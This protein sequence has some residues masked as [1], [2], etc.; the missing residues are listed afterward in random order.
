MN[1][2]PALQVLFSPSHALDKQQL[3][4]IFNCKN[5]I[6]NHPT[7]PKA[8]SY[9]PGD[10]SIGLEETKVNDHLSRELR[11]YLLDELY[12]HLWLV[13]RR[14]GRSIDALH[15]QRLKGRS[16]VPTED[17]NL[18]LIWHHNQIY[19]KPIPVC[20]FNYDFWEIYLSPTKNN[21]H[22][23]SSTFDCSIAM[24]FLR[25]YAFLISHPLDF[26]L[27]KESH[28]VP[29]DIDWIAWSKFIQRFR[30]L[31]DEQV[32]NRFHYGQLRL[33]RLNWVV[34]I[35][36]PQHANTLWFYHIPHWSITTYLSQ[37]TIPLLFIFASVSV[38][39]SAMQVVFIVFV[40][41]LG[42]NPETTWRARELTQTTNASTEYPIWVSDFL[43]DDLSTPDDQ[44][45]RIFFFNFDSFWMRDAVETRLSNIG[46]DL[47]E[48]ITNTIRQSEACVREQSA[49]YGGGKVRNIGLPV[50]H[51]GLNKFG[52]RDSNYQAILAILVNTMSAISPK[53]LRQAPNNQAELSIPLQLPM[54]RNERFT[55]REFLLQQIHYHLQED[56]QDMQQ[57]IVALYGPGGI[58]KTQTAAEYAYHY[59]SRYNSVFWIDGASEHTIRQ[60]FSLVAGQIL[61][62]WRMLNH[63]ETAY[64]IFAKEFGVGSLEDGKTSRT[65]TAHQA[66][67]GVIDWLSQSEN[68]EWLLI[69]DNIDD[70]DSFDIRSYL[71]SSQHGNILITSRRT[72]VSGYWKSIEVEKMS[73]NEAK[74]LLAKSSGFSGNM[75][76]EVSLEL[77]HLLGH[78]PLA[79][80][81]AGAY[82]SV[83]H[84]FLPHESDLYSQALQRYINEYHLNAERLLKHKR[85]QS[86]WDYRNDTILTTW[87]V[88][89][90]RIEIDIPEA[91][92]L[93]LL[94]GFLSNNDIFEELFTY[95]R[96]QQYKKSH[97]HQEYALFEGRVSS[98]LHA[99]L[100]NVQNLPSDTKF[101]DLRNSYGPPSDISLP[102]PLSV[103]YAITEGWLLWMRATILEIRLSFLLTFYEV[104]QVE[105][106]IW[107]VAYKLTVIL[108]DHTLHKHTEQPFRWQFA[109]ARRALHPKHPR[110]LSIAGDIAWI[111]LLQDRI[112]ES[113][114]WYEWVLLSRQRV[115]GPQH[116]ATLGAVMGIASIL[117]RD[118]SHHE[119]LDLRIMA[120]EGRAARLGTENPLTLN[121]AHVIGR[122][123]SIEGRYDDAVKWFQLVF[124]GRNTTLGPDH[125][126]TLQ[127]A[128]EIAN[129][130][131]QLNRH[132][133]A[134][135]WDQTVWKGRNKM[136]GPNHK[137]TL[138]SAHYIG[139]VL[140][141]VDRYNDALEW[142]QIAWEGRNKTLG[143]DHES[144]LESAQNIGQSLFLL[145]RYTEALEWDQIAWKGRNK[146]LG[147]DHEDTLQSTHNIGR[148]K[149]WGPDHEDTLESSC[150]IGV[151]FLALGKYDEAIKWLNSALQGNMRILGRDHEDAKGFMTVIEAVEQLRDTNE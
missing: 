84:K 52:S 9:L 137:S 146:T 113:R 87:E 4:P 68:S 50:D 81:Q 106:D 60:S 124:Y 120:Y 98:H 135:E 10:P 39:L 108:R 5:S 37:A 69:F 40:H 109:E 35:F 64:R 58:G 143:P 115:Q 111:L 70:L 142:S 59:Q 72:D 79:I 51:E 83:Q 131:F 38:V 43:P 89:L 94:C 92:E 117:E 74:S 2:S 41:G 85:P 29:E 86:I 73:E 123:F 128:C 88:S 7:D 34:R 91:S 138:Q 3:K 46:N 122:Q 134:L 133:E 21:N 145:G 140:S 76:E 148:N 6:S 99:A 147:P 150:G 100:K 48:H 55:G 110:A 97:S 102:Q 112:Q 95:S 53:R 14:S 121:S 130:L 17:P 71:P 19:I 101:L 125:E 114:K 80:E 116:Y 24:G 26:I 56:C 65:P 1:A 149:I 61:K 151:I 25:S 47:L 132:N 49:K 20:L 28:L 57:C 11:T 78:F 16:V 8:I 33:S 23:M 36:R 45:V 90:Q 75:N 30:E 126:D 77:L 103:V 42:S 13:G 105:T 141:L 96:F 15:A 66:V 54:A 67:K 107:W 127:S 129:S 82:I 63:N 31:G 93:L 119:A 44:D 22:P 27:A 104:E 12:D 144:T 18:H 139:Y 118:G 62:S 136:F 32:A